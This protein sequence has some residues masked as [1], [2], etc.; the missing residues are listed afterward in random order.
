MYSNSNRKVIHID[1][2]TYMRL[3]MLRNYYSQREHRNVSLAAIIKMLSE[4]HS[5]VL[6]SQD[7]VFKIFFGVRP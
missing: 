5:S 2:E 3:L 7:S 6:A 1:N 4:Q